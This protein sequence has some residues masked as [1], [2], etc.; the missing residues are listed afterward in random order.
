[1]IQ[2]IASFV[3][4]RTGLV[5]GTSLFYGYRPQDAP[6][7]CATI[8]FN[9]GAAVMFDIPSRVD[10]MVQILTRAADYTDAYNDARLAFETLHGTAGWTLPV[11]TSGNTYELYDVEAV[12][13]PQ[14]LGEDEKGLHEWSVN[15]LFRIRKK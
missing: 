6:D 1:M 9:G 15:F 11:I 8:A 2:E 5:L 13:A 12:E 7:H 10:Q 4:T 14:Y 3:A